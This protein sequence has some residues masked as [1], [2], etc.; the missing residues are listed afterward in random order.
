MADT[1][2]Q[3]EEAAVQAL[4]PGFKIV[5]RAPYEVELP[6]PAKTPSRPD[7]P[8]TV[9]QTVGTILSIEG[10]NGEPDKMTTS[11]M[12]PI[13]STTGGTTAKGGLGVT[14]L[15]GPSKSA[16][17]AGTGLTSDPNKWQAVYRP[18]TTD[19]VGTWDPVNNNFHAIAAPPQAQP[20]GKYDPVVVK[21]P[22]GTER[23]V[24]LT[25]TGDRSFHP[26]AAPPTNPSGKYDNVYVTNADGSQRLVGMT[27]TGDKRF[28]P[29]SADPTTNKR[30]IQTPTAVYSVDDNDNVKK[31]IDIDKNV[32][33]QAVVIDGTVYSFD[34]NEKDPTKRLV[35]VS[36]QNLPQTIK[37][38]DTTWVLQKNDDG[39]FEYKLPPGITQPGNLQTNTTARTLDWYDAQGNLIKSVPNK[40]YQAPQVN[41]PTVNAVSPF[42]PVPDPNS[43]NGWRWEKNEA[44]V[45]ASAA[46]Q[47]L[48]SQLSGHV[49]SGDISVEEAKA[50]IDG[51]NTAMQTATTAATQ[52]LSAINQGA[53]AGANLLAERSR[54]GQ[55]FVTEGLG[56]LGRGQKGLLVAP[57]ADFAQNLVQGAAGFAT[58]LG[59][60][61]DV[62]QAAANLVRRAD[63]TGSMGQDA[64]AAFSALT[65]MFQAYRQTHGGQPAP[66]ETQALK[67]AGVGAG[68]G[69]GQQPGQQTF[70]SVPQQTPA[71]ASGTVAPSGAVAGQNYGYATAF[72]GGGAGGYANVSNPIGFQAPQPF[73]Q[74][75]LP[76]GR[77]VAVPSIQP[78]PAPLTMPVA[79]S[80]TF[81]APNM[82]AIGGL[83][84]VVPQQRNITITVPT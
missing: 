53:Q 18:G 75:G 73:A 31:L 67:G 37:Q 61:P 28:I 23:Q 2:Y 39:S 11:L 66:E 40:N 10:P 8:A 65:Q 29:V 55:Q 43:P 68:T 42:I 81:A 36:Q 54:A 52:T 13:P 45:T 79:P 4:R 32:P 34:P 22:D 70:P 44:R 57:P 59:G 56:I 5:G 16:T 7:L 9:K 84:P 3:S 63:P 82:P 24:G 25:D 30:T 20:T 17:P 60:G 74:S 6:N 14:V 80:P 58:Q 71:E 15:S 83:G 35:Q 27:D 62:F 33:L 77:S 19:I 49:V 21:D 1:A 26:L 76:E 78:V 51:A 69:T 41:L 12:G 72:P 64:G 47:S 38:G 46:L 50:I 48:A